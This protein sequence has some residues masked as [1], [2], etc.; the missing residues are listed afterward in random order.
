MELYVNNYILI[1][2]PS[3]ELKYNTEDDDNY[4]L[5]HVRLKNL[6]K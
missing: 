2:I 3:N 6:G 1:Y 5:Y 4:R